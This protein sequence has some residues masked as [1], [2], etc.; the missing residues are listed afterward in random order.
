MSEQLTKD[1]KI[2][3]D[4]MGEFLIDTDTQIKITN[5]VTKK[6]M[7]DLASQ[8]AEN[9][10]NKV[11]TND[12]ILDQAEE[13]HKS[14]LDFGEKMNKS[15]DDLNKKL[16]DLNDMDNM[17]TEEICDMLDGIISMQNDAQ[18]RRGFFDLR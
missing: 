2:D 8:K 12:K 4:K 11:N 7:E 3:W 14:L 10:K 9:E 15:F 18:N 5:E 13:L 16:D 17:Y 6:V 1:G